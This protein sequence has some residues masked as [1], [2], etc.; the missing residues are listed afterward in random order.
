MSI[1]EKLTKIAENEQSISN[2]INTEADLIAEIKSM[3]D[4][5]PEAGGGGGEDLWQYVTT[6]NQTFQYYAFPEGYELTLNVPN[7][8]MDRDIGNILTGAT[9][10][11]KLILKCGRDD[12]VIR[13]YFAFASCQTVEEIDLSQFC[14]TEIVRITKSDYLFYGAK[15]LKTIHG[16]LDFSQCTAIGT[17]FSGANQ[18]VNITIAPT[19][20]KVDFNIGT[21]TDLSAAS[22]QSIIDGLA[23]LSAFTTQT[24]TLHATV[25]AK[26]TQEQKD[27][28]AAKN[29]TLAY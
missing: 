8:S 16:V 4:N 29:W 2:G 28:A 3:V 27:A 15:R 9:G 21:C 11:R 18:I 26:L 10:L 23:D 7:L 13:S 1:S 17:P 6:L 19:S 24:L 14:S 12:A 25:G 22:I 5:L 20:I